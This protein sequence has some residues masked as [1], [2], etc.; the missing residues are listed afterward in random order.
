M[1]ILYLFGGGDENS[2]FNKKSKLLSF[3][4]ALTIFFS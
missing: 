2:I 1:V 3:I 4:T